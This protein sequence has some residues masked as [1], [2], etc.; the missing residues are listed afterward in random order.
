VGAETRLEALGEVPANCVVRNT[1]DQIA[2]LK[3]ADLFV[4]HC[5]M[6]SVSEALWFGVPL[7]LWPQTPEQQSVAS[8]VQEL[9]A[10]RAL[11]AASAESI[12]A[13]IR[14]ALADQTLKEG[15]ERIQGS[16]RA[17]GG[18]KEAADFIE[19]QAIKE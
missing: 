17:C 3:G 12:R 6:N 8:R 14:T 11:D 15:A 18:A 16:L 4:T 10:G 19:K 7:L 5:G 2:V 13:A 1:V 9:G